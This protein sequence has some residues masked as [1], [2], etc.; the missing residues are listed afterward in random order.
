MNIKHPVV[1]GEKQC[2]K[3]GRWLPIDDFHTHDSR[4]GYKKTNCKKCEQERHRI[5]YLKHGGQKE[6]RIRTK[7]EKVDYKGGVCVLC[8]Y[9]K[10]VG[11][12]E[13]HHVNPD[14]K[15]HEKTSIDM[16]LER[17][18]SELDKCILVCANCHREIHNG[19]YSKEELA[20]AWARKDASYNYNS[21]DSIVQISR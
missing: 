11:S 16:S 6:R 5:H 10:Y 4:W 21:T 12:L 13:F 18:K 15:D 19:F 8:G 14:E 3:C 7:I 2:G 17:C 20:V 1:N 9:D